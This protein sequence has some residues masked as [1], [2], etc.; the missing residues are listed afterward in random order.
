[1]ARATWGIDRRTFRGTVDADGTLSGAIPVLDDGVLAG[2]LEITLTADRVLEVVWT[3]EPD[4]VDPV[5]YRAWQ[6]G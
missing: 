6:K 3:T 4:A 5:D 2:T 1:M